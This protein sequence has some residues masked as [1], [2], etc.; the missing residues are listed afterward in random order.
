M[1]TIEEIAQGVDTD[2]LIFTS[3]FCPYCVAV[4][5]LLKQH[6]LTFT[7]FNFD[8][9]PSLR[10][11]VVTKTGHRTVPVVLDLRDGIMFIGGFNETSSYLS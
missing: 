6:K 1:P 3:T 5:R 11:E 2:F 10:S 7:E 4:K 9:E 8:E